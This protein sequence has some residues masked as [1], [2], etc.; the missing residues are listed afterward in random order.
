MSYLNNLY[1]ILKQLDYKRFILIIIFMIVAT[2]LEFLSISLIVPFIAILT[3]QN[4]SFLNY[5]PDRFLEIFLSLT[6]EK[7]FIYGIFIF[8]LIYLIKSIY[9]IFFN[10]K[11]NQFVFR[12]EAKLCGKWLKIIHF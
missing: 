10:L 12:S 8:F 5:L 4:T 9:L 11:L 7:I 1:S 6:K 2:I 3:E